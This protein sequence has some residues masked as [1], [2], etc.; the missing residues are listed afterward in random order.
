MRSW[1]KKSLIAVVIAAQ[2]NLVAVQ[3][4]YADDPAAPPSIPAGTNDQLTDMLINIIS[5]PLSTTTLTLGL[6]YAFWRSFGNAKT[7][8]LNVR[9]A[10]DTRATKL[11]EAEAAKRLSVQ[12]KVYLDD[13]PKRIEALEYANKILRNEI[14]TKTVSAARADHLDFPGLTGDLRVRAEARFEAARQAALTAKK[15]KPAD[16]KAREAA[17][18]RNNIQ[19]ARLAEKNAIFKFAKRV[20]EVAKHFQSLPKDQRTSATL[21]AAERAL[22]DAYN[23][24]T[25]EYNRLVSPHLRQPL[26]V[27]RSSAH[28]DTL[29]RYYLAPHNESNAPELVGPKKLEGMLAETCDKKVALLAKI[30]QKKQA[31]AGFVKSYKSQINAVGGLVV[32]SSA[33]AA[34]IYGFEQRFK[35]PFTEARSKSRVADKIT[36]KGKTDIA[37]QLADDR[38]GLKRMDP[39]YSI[40]IESVLAH[41]IELLELIGAKMSPEDRE[42]F[43]TFGGRPESRSQ[44]LEKRMLQV[45]AALA[46]RSRRLAPSADKKPRPMEDAEREEL[47]R[48]SASVQYATGKIFATSPSLDSVVALVYTDDPPT[49]DT[50]LKES[51]KM[52]YR[53]AIATLFTD[54]VDQRLLDHVESSVIPAMRDET[55]KGLAKHVE[56]LKK[57]NVDIVPKPVAPIPGTAPKHA[58]EPVPGINPALTGSADKSAQVSIDTSSAASKALESLSLALPNSVLSTTGEAER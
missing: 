18:E 53:E 58:D 44:K 21:E 26:L 15:L 22:F 41:E 11:E 5:N 4:A 34:F 10:M 54:L 14:E 55:L 36:E 56:S 16:I 31:D 27:E 20:R 51:L 37:G 48:V 9:T 2:V 8:L 32:A 50:I 17:I 29:K 6:A 1:W 28:S 43:V 3:P 25:E 30:T 42:E 35:M 7:A 46:A 40:G 38:K 24:P 39:F 49:R 57:E 13:Y 33:A 19:I 47:E 52:L 45:K 23:G 12:E